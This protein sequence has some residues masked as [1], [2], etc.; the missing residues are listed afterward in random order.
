MVR[1]PWHG[2]GKWNLTK[3]EPVDF[4]GTYSAEVTGDT[5]HL[6]GMKQGA[7]FVVKIIQKGSEITGSNGESAEKQTGGII[8]GE[9]EGDTIKF[10]WE[11]STGISVGGIWTINRESNE[12]TGTW[13]ADNTWYGG[14]KW[15]LTKIEAP[16]ATDMVQ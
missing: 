15:N 14:G 8:W 5:K 12:I 2:S 4:T 9:L 10:S 16:S 13:N 1:N 3:I 11:N 6:F 7:K